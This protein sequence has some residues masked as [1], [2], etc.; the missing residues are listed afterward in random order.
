MIADNSD[1]WPIETAPKDGSRILVWDGE[2]EIVR[3]DDVSHDYRKGWAS[4]GLFSEHA[5]WYDESFPTHWQPLPSAPATRTPNPESPPCPECNPV[6]ESG[7]QI[8]RP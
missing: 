4:G 2:P 1:W 5:W 6:P 3:W 8:P 7:I